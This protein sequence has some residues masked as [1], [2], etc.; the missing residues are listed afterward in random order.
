MRYSTSVRS[1][2]P[3]YNVFQMNMAEVGYIYTTL[4]LHRTIK[5][6]KYPRKNKIK[7]KNRLKKLVRQL[8]FKNSTKVIHCGYRKANGSKG[9]FRKGAIH[10]PSFSFPCDLMLVKTF[11]LFGGTVRRKQFKELNS[12]PSCRLHFIISGFYDCWHSF[13]FQYGIIKSMRLD[14]AWQLCNC[15]LCS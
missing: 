13:L 10:V 6:A 5:V 15:E 3:N 9:H 12:E 11:P 8:V 4:C 2:W 14:K 1:R 7:K